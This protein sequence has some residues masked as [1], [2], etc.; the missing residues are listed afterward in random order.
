MTISITGE[1]ETK[2][3]IQIA[4]GLQ[5]ITPQQSYVSALDFQWANTL[6]ANLTDDANLKI[7]RYLGDDGIPKFIYSCIHEKYVAGR[8][9]IKITKDIPLISQLPDTT[10]ISL[11]RHIVHSLKMLPL[12]YR[13][14]MALLAQFSEPILDKVDDRFLFPSNICIARPTA[15]PYTLTVHANDTLIDQS[16]FT[17]LFDDDDGETTRDLDSQRYYFSMP[18]NGFAVRSSSTPLGR[19]FEDNIRA[20]YGAGLA[21]KLF[22]FGYTKSAKVLPYIMIHSETTN[23]L[24]ATEKIEDDLQKNEFRFGTIDFM[25][26]QSPGGNFAFSKLLNTIS[27]IFN[28]DTDCRKLHTACIWFYRATINRRPLD[29]LLESTIAIEVMLGDRKV[30][31]GIGLSNLLGNR[32]AFLLGTSSGARHQI[33]NNFQTIYKLRSNIVHEGRH[34]LQKGDRNIV[35]L[36]LRMCASIIARELII[37]AKPTS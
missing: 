17:D 10:A 36:A 26:R 32:C 25:K 30:S 20:F 27:T 33:M 21:T 37:R 4:E 29:S 18:M 12:R 13:L 35:N 1:L 3:I 34:S 28:D 11:A 5:A 15:L 22:S 31:E 23:E 16:L 2:L 6:T 9:R 7:D 8:N 24:L 14:T 19:A